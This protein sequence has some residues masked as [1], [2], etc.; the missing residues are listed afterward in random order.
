MHLP[1]KPHPLTRA[2]PYVSI[3]LLALLCGRPL[4]A[5]DHAADSDTRRIITKITPPF[6]ELARRMHVSGTVHL[7]ATVSADGHVEKAKAVSGPPLLCGPAQDA[8]MRWKFAPAAGET[9]VSVQI[10]FSDGER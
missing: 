8:V 4:H 7:D 10:N 3:V 6:P 1:V 2:I 5:S 9:T